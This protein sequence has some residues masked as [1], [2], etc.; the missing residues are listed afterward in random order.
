[1]KLRTY[2]LFGFVLEAR[3]YRG[4]SPGA[5]VALS[6]DN[7]VLARMSV[8]S[9]NAAVGA[10]VAVDGGEGS[11]CAH[12]DALYVAAYF[13]VHA[14]LLA[15]AVAGTSNGGLDYSV[16]AHVET[17]STDYVY[18]TWC[19]GHERNVG[20]YNEPW[21]RHSFIV[22]ADILFGK[23]AYNKVATESIVEGVS[24]PMPEGTYVATAQRFAEVWTRPRWNG[25]WYRRSMWELKVPG[26]GIPVSDHGGRL[27]IYH[28]RAKHLCQAVGQFVGTALHERAIYTGTNNPDGLATTQHKALVRVALA[29]DNKQHEEEG[30]G[31][32]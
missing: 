28:A 16:R 4:Y 20:L 27:D 15:R 2:S 31:L 11:V 1:M 29:S 3:A 8:S 22:P 13:T 32:G 17:E 7:K 23:C 25:H 19:F 10:G 14:P 30:G 21:W 9:N 5:S 18:L 12:V 26:D 24:I 6:R